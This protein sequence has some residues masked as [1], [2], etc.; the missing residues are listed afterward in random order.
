VVVA[1]RDGRRVYYR[2]SDPGISDWI[3]A[4]AGLRLRPGASESDEHTAA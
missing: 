3:R 1:R 2:L 4:G